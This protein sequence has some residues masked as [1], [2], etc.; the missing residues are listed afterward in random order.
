MPE[1]QRKRKEAAGMP[2]SR[3]GISEALG[4]AMPGRAYADISKWSAWRQ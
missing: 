1:K 2:A 4:S 3:P